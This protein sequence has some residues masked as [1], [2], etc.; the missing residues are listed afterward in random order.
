VDLLSTQRK[1]I[2][3]CGIQEMNLKSDFA[4][5]V[6]TAVSQSS[7]S[8]SSSIRWTDLTPDFRELQLDCLTS[9]VAQ[10]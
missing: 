4:N 1:Q 6:A 5:F 2:D 3:K 8:L 10:S 7:L 9:A